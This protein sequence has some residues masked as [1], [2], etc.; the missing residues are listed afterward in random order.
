MKQAVLYIHGRGGDPGEAAHYR[1]LFPDCAVLGAAYTGDTPWDAA[2]ELLACCD[3]AEEKYGSVILIANSIGVYFA[4]NA[5]RERRPEK[6]FFISPIVDMEALIRAMMAANGTSEEELRERGTVQTAFGE[7]LSWAY[8][9]YV[10]EHPLLWRV[11][12][13]I[14]Y[15]ERDNLIAY[16]TAARFAEE[17]GADLTVMPG[18]EHWFHTEAQ[19]AFL[20]DW[21]RA[22]LARDNRSGSRG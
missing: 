11:P 4:M 21:V 18:G 17:C 22:C 14:L 1:P 5:R 12:T 6:A 19:M 15:G 13:H 2:P 3:E 10:R 20:D 7:T 9:T 16:P 8:L